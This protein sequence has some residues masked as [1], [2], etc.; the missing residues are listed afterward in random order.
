M[1]NPFVQK[2]PPSHDPE[3]G[4][5][6]PLEPQSP[7]PSPIDPKEGKALCNAEY[8]RMPVVCLLLY[9]LGGVSLLLYI[10]MSKSTAF[11]DGFNRTVGAALRSVLSLL[12]GWIPFSVGEAVILLLPLGLFLVL[13]HAVRHRCGSWRAAAVYVGILLSV[14]ITLFSSFTFTFAAGYRGTSLD[15]KL[16]L[17]RTPVSAQELY[18]TAVILIDNINRETA[19]VMYEPGG[20]SAMPYSHEEMNRRLNATYAKVAEEYDFI[21]HVDSRVKPV[22]VSEVMSYMHIT[23][24]Y[25]FFTGEA[26]LNVNFPDYTL[27]YTAAHEMAHQRG[28]AREDEANFMAFLVS[29]ASDDP[30]VRYCG[31]LNAYEYVASALWRADSELYYKAV[32]HLNPEVQGEMAAYREFYDKYREST[33]SQVS[34]AVND[35]YLQS[36]GTPGTVSYGMV[37]ELTV[38]YYRA[39]AA[40]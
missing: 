28:I 34:G 18:D 20:F 7:S 29:V 16:G 12:T 5:K 31:Y 11:A 36:Q 24:V 15:Q 6:T 21:T 35:S 38:A 14:V 40:S 22:L 2:H 19:E 3:K 10:L 13:R 9:G 25:S 32:A 8:E 26:N 33:V 37:V 1:K 30:Y 23:G 27:P 39:E 17:E 4:P